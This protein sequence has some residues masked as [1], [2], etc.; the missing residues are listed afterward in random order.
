[1]R[2]ASTAIIAI[3]LTAVPSGAAAD[4][5][6]LFD[7]CGATKRRSYDHPAFHA[8]RPDGR[9]FRTLRDWRIHRVTPGCPRS[10]PSWSPSGRRIVYRHGNGIATA[11][12]RLRDRRNLHPAGLWPTWSPDGDRIAFTGLDDRGRDDGLVTIPAGGGRV[13]VV[14]R[15]AS[16]VLL[17][18]WRPDGEVLLFHTRPPTDPR[19]LMVPAGGGPVR[20]LGPG[21][22]PAYAPG[23]DRIAFV[24]AGT[25]WTMRPDGSRRQRLTTPA[26]G[27]VV[28][29]VA[30]SPDG[31]RIAYL[32]DEPGDSIAVFIRV[33]PRAGGTPRTVALPH[34]LCCPNSL[35]WS[36]TSPRRTGVSVSRSKRQSMPDNDAAARG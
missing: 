15:V 30:W 22:A 27:L 13:R 35:S 29:R 8:I 12:R 32:E 6:L 2:R 19:V 18:S 10:E 33:I 16:G 20:D 25:V 14:A 5:L 9:G 1:V 21:S 26:T 24:H 34:D 3:M 7:T 23:G 11:N 4:G 17:P 31:R 28:E 36:R